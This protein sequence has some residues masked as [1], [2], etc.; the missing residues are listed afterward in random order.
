MHNIF[1]QNFNKIELQLYIVPYTQL[2]LQTTSDVT[3]KID[4]DQLSCLTGVQTTQYST[5]F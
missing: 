2:K 5:F 4:N 1:I 3:T